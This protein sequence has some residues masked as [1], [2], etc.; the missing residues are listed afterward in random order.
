M[1]RFLPDSWHEGLLRPLLLADPATA[2]YYEDAAPDWRFAVLAAVLVFAAAS[3]RFGKLAT[4]EH[5]RWLLMLVVLLY[6]WTFTI[7]NGRYFIAGLMLVGPML[8]LAWQWMPGTRGFRWA[9][10][11]S[12]MAAQAHTVNSLYVPGSWAL[13]GW[14]QG[15]AVNVSPSPAREKPAVFITFTAIS[16]SMLVPSFH[17]GS[18][19]ANLGGQVDMTPT[20]PEYALS[21]ALL[22]SPLPKYV[23][24]PATQAEDGPDLQPGPLMWRMISR[25]MREHGLEPAADRCESVRTNLTPHGKTQRGMG[26]PLGAF[27]ICPIRLMDAQPPSQQPDNEEMN[28]VFARL[29]AYCPRFFPPGGGVTKRNEDHWLRY[30]LGTDT[31]VYVEDGGTVTYKYYR[32]FTA[33]VVASVDNVRQGR[34]S[35]NCEKLEGRYRPPWQSH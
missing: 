21:R 27:W 10:L 15:P 28:D 12:F 31:R 16:Y 25:A 22:A 3:G 18:R 29:E 1:L 5:R 33:T 32:H 24:L 19:W 2:L 4:A 9:L 7:G 34:F 13:A 20:R 8:V 6:T 26:K 17:P 14:S 11:L 23:L 35:F 30:Y